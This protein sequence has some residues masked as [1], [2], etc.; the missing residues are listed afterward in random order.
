MV[1][2][3]GCQSRATPDFVRIPGGTFLM[4]CVA[5]DRDCH[6]D[7]QPRHLERLPAPF[8]MQRTE[9]TVGEWRR[10]TRATGYRSEAEQTG[11]GRMFVAARHTWEWIVGFRCVRDSAP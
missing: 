5:G 8:W 9:T 4:G 1:L 7:E 2:V 10:F 3:L 11:R 6:S